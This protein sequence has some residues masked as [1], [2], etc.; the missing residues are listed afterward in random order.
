MLFRSPHVFKRDEGEPSLD[1]ASQVKVRWEE[2][3]AQE[4]GG[5]AKAETLLSGIPRA[6]PALLRA[7]QIGARAHSVG[8]DWDTPTDVVAKIREEVEEVAEVV[9]AEG[10]LDRERAEEE[11][12]DLLFAISHLSRRLGIEPEAALRKANDKFTRRFTAMETRI[13]ARGGRMADMTIDA[14]EAEW[15]QSKAEEKA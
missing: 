5:K 7:Y 13:G 11:M 6:L 3:K 9:G 8:F 12:G 15:Q 10:T 14:L 1:T 2:V 4:R